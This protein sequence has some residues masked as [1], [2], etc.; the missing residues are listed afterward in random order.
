VWNWSGALPDILTWWMMV[1]L[2][3][4]PVCLLR[5]FSCEAAFIDF[6]LAISKF[7]DYCDFH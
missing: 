7:A 4:V 3:P 2:N 6:R 5:L 1:G